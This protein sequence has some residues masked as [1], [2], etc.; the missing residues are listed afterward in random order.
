YLRILKA[1]DKLKKDM[2]N[3]YEDKYWSSLIAA[4]PVRSWQQSLPATND[5]QEH[6][7]EIKADALPVGE[8]VLIAATDKDFTGKKTVLGARLFYMSSISFI[9][10]QNDFFVVDRDNGQ[11]L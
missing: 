2:E 8:Y 11:P 7:V 10:S 6:S 4:K 5:M 1:D 3:E 9:N